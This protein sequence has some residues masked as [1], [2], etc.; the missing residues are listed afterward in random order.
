VEPLFG[1]GLGRPVERLLRG[2]DLVLFGGTSHEGARQP[3]PALKGAAM[4]RRSF[5]FAG[6]L[7]CPSGSSGT[8]AASDA[9]PA[10]RPLPGVN[11]VKRAR[12]FR[13]RV[14]RAAGPGRA[15]PV[16]AATF[17][18]FRVRLRRGVL[19]GR[20]SRLF[21]ASMA[22]ALFARARRSLFPAFAGEASNDA[23]GFA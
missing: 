18:T 6:G 13:R 5:P 11:P 16:P 2:L 3:F 9:L 1:V 14:S 21:T 4:K 15:S 20:A 12:R 19:R 10:P 8:T 22:V 23:A 17:R 7:R